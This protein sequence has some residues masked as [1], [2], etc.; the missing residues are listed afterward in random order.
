M[1][2]VVADVGYRVYSALS[3]FDARRLPVLSLIAAIIAG[4]Q[5][6]CCFR[7]CR[8]CILSL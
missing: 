2:D 6:C 3:F 7:Y 1:S 4:V 5:V 8:G